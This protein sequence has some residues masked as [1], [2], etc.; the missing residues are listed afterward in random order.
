[1]ARE[2]A[3]AYLLARSFL[4]AFV[5]VRPCKQ[6]LTRPPFPPVSLFSSRQRVRLPSL[7][8]RRARPRRKDVILPAHSSLSDHHSTINHRPCSSADVITSLSADHLFFFPCFFS[9]A[10]GSRYGHKTLPFHFHP[11]HPLS[12]CIHHLTCPPEPDK[13]RA[14]ARA[15]AREE[16][17]RTTV[18]KT[19]CTF[20][21]FRHTF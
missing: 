18:S 17:E 3:R 8:R 21:H 5:P 7:E 16:K 19:R 11:L 13:R 14:R 10:G 15:R 12:H 1:M 6:R 20:T 9:L 2:C 4:P